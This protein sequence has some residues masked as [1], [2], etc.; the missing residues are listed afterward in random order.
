MK[1]K[2]HSPVW[3]TPTAPLLSQHGYEG[4]KAFFEELKPL[5]DTAVDLARKMPDLREQVGHLMQ[6]PM[7]S[8]FQANSA[9]QDI[10]HYLE[11]HLGVKAE[12]HPILYLFMYRL[13]LLIIQAA[14]RDHQRLGHI[15]G[16]AARAVRDTRKLQEGGWTL[17]DRRKELHKLK[18]EVCE[19]ALEI[20]KAHPT[21]SCRRVTRK[22]KEEVRYNNMGESTIRNHIAHLFRS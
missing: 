1:E 13:Q 20:R 17:T 19:K 21:W 8:A 3:N 18:D 11:D 14:Y 10:L 5:M 9:C 12:E 6:E 4:Q 22:I 7:L 2:Y 15:L 16:D